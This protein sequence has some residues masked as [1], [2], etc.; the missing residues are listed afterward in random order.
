MI[1]DVIRQQAQAA[2]VGDLERR[3]LDSSFKFDAYVLRYASKFGAGGFAIGAGVAGSLLL[4]AAILWPFVIPTWPAVALS[5]LVGL[6]GF[7]LGLTWALYDQIKAYDEFNRQ[8]YSD[9]M[10]FQADP[11]APTSRAIPFQSNGQ[12]Q[13]IEVGHPGKDVDAIHLPGE[14]VLQMMD[15]INRGD[16]KITRDKF[17]RADGKPYLTGPTWL[18]LATGNTGHGIMYKRGYWSD[19]N[20]WT[21]QGEEWLKR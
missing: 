20:E 13:V 7:G 1:E 11:P 21:P 6:I 14:L 2:R 17:T 10:T 18:K 15:A 5:A 4:I 9:R 16:R 19:E 8:A 12:H 3:R